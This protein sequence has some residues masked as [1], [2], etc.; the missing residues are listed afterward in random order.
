[1]EN[2]NQTDRRKDKVYAQV[3]GTHSEGKVAQHYAAMNLLTL[4]GDYSSID[5]M[6]A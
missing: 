5:L 1:L 2:S 6:D 3:R 4:I